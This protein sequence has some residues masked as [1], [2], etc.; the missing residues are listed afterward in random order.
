MK[1]VTFLFAGF[2]VALVAGSTVGCGGKKSVHVGYAL[3]TFPNGVVAI[4]RTE[5][6]NVTRKS[7]GVFCLQW[8]FSTKDVVVQVSTAVDDPERART[9]VAVWRVDARNCGGRATQSSSG[10]GSGGG[11]LEVDTYDC[12]TSCTPKDVPFMVNPTG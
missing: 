12:A 6:L 5:N 8:N 1:R 2:V 4:Q 11:Q 9:S 3:V 7:A 10:S